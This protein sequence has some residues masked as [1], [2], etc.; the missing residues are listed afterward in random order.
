MYIK[1]MIARILFE[2]H[3]RVGNDLPVLEW[4]NDAIGALYFFCFEPSSL[5]VCGGPDNRPRLGL[6]PSR[7]CH[8]TCQ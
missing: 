6:W 5:P 2:N 8:F 3:V 1:D 7:I 4:L